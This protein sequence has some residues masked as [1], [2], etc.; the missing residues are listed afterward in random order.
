MPGLV[1]DLVQE[2]VQ[3]VADA[4]Q[5]PGLHHRQIWIRAEF[6]FESGPADYG[7]T[8]SALVGS[9]CGWWLSVLRIFADEL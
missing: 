7:N 9:V 1:T 4:V 3:R 6:E 8:E 2:L 5:P